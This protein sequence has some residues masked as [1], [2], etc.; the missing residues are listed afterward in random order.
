M[1]PIHT[2]CVAVLQGYHDV[3]SND[4]TTLSCKLDTPSKMPEW[5]MPI[6]VVLSVTGFML[7][8]AV[9]LMV[10]LRMTVSLRKRWQRDKELMRSRLKGVPN[11]GPAS[12][13]VTDVEGYSGEMVQDCMAGECVSAA[14]TEAAAHAD[15][16]E[17]STTVF[18][19]TSQQV[20]FA[21]CR[22]DAAVRCSYHT[23]YGC[24]Q[25]HLA[26]GCYSSCWPCY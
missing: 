3:W 21:V 7:L 20:T 15:L 23:G 24:P 12:I 19:E 26:Q 25:C 22:V 5:V 2:R 14:V 16:S 4:H 8:A 9:A 6:A 1:G 18:Q 10:W 13:V 11:G 17:S